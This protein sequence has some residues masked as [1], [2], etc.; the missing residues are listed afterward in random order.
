MK[1]IWAQQGVRRLL[2]Y[3]LFEVCAVLLII[4][5]TIMAYGLTRRAQIEVETEQ[6]HLV[7]RPHYLLQLTTVQQELRGRMPDLERVLRLIHNPQDIITFIEDMEETAAGYNIDVEVPSI[8][9]VKELDEAGVPIEERGPFRSISL[10][11]HGQGKT[12][13][14][15]QFLHEIEHAAYLVS[16]KDW[17]IAA[18][19]V[20]VSPAPVTAGARE[21]GGGSSVLALPKVGQ[22]DAEFILVVHNEGYE[23]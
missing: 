21:V 9:E 7:N 3:R 18:Q 4:F 5:A 8:N 11:I 10:T 22:L 23:P 16:L 15:L 2:L 17:S 12:E 13:N 19:S 14:L 1:K 20:T 6:K